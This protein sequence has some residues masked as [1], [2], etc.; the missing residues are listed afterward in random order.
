M[1]RRLRAAGY[2]SAVCH[3]H[4]AGITYTSALHTPAIAMQCVAMR[5]LLSPRQRRYAIRRV[6]SF[7]LLFLRPYE[8]NTTT[9][10]KITPS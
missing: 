3:H 10:P 6:R 8:Q 2:Q 4:V 5:L 1:D 7:V 9:V